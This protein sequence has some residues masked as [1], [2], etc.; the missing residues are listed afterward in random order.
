MKISLT[1]AF[2]L[3]LTPHA[4]FAQNTVKWTMPGP[5]SI[6]TAPGAVTRVDLRAH[7]ENG[8]R[9]YSLTQK[10][11]GPFAMSIAL[12]PGSRGK[13][14]GAVIAPTPVA[15]YDSSFKMMTETYSGD[16]IFGVMLRAPV[17]E[18]TTSTTIKVRYQACSAR[19]CL[20]PRTELFQVLLKVKK[21]K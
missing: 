18:G 13:I 16:A 8:W 17:E 9:I 5:H 6:T 10:K 1:A 2:F 3:V 14:E 19:F 11:G 4:A 12:L 15:K 21:G 7:I 20:P